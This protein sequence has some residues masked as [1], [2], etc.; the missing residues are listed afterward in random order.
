MRTATVS[1]LP[2]SGESLQ[3]DEFNF[4]ITTTNSRSRYLT[5]HADRPRGRLLPP[6]RGEAQTGCESRSTPPS[7]WRLCGCVRTPQCRP[8]P[9]DSHNTSRTPPSPWRSRGRRARRGRWALAR[10]RVAL[11]RG[12]GAALPAVSAM[13]RRRRGPRSLRRAAPR[14]PPHGV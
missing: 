2:P 13:R 7:L 10:R 9:T 11:A 8:R 14:C 3:S 4:K 1:P 6:G 12:G 5:G